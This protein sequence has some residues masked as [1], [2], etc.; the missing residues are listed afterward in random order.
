MKTKKEF[1]YFSIFQYEQEQEY[2]RRRH[3]EGWRFVKVSGLG[4]YHFEECTPEDVVYQLDYNQEGLAHKEEYVQMFRDCGWEYLQ[5]YAGYSYFCKS[6][7]QMD[8]EE[9]I[10]CDDQSRLE[11]M[12]RVYK[13][14]LVPVLVLFCAVLLPQFIMNLTI[15]HNFFLS[16]M[17]GVILVLYLAVFGS[18]VRHYRK[19]KGNTEK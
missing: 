15:Y 6:A 2:L 14:R 11:M 1:R 4:V 9:E 18:A 7:S 19:L 16:A 10:F 3:Q 12:E 8:G 13:G 5:D 17:Y